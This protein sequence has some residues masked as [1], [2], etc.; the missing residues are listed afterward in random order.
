MSC[1]AWSVDGRSVYAARNIKEE[2]IVLVEEASD[3]D[4]SS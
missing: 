2:R 4:T 3:A 1:Y